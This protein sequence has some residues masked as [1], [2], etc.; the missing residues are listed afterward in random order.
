MWSMTKLGSMAL[1]NTVPFSMSRFVSWPLPWEPPCIYSRY[2]GYYCSK[3]WSMDLIT[4]SEVFT[5]ETPVEELGCDY[6]T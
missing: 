3:S 6:F 1:R 2:G 5:W 4:P